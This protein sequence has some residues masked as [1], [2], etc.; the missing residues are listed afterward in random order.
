MKDNKQKRKE[1]TYT[2]DIQNLIIA[3]KVDIKKDR[4]AKIICSDLNFLGRTIKYLF[5]E[6]E[7]LSDEQAGN[8]ICNVIVEDSNQT[9]T[10]KDL[11]IA[12]KYIDVSFSIK[13]R[14]VKIKLFIEPN[15]YK[16]NIDE[17]V[18]RSLEY[19]AGYYLKEREEYKSD[20]T[21]GVDVYGIWIL[22]S[23]NRAGTSLIWEGDIK[24]R[25]GKIK[26]DIKLS[27]HLCFHFCYISNEYDKVDKFKE[28]LV[29]F[30]STV[31]SKIK[32]K[33][34]KIKLLEERQ[35]FKFRERAQ[36]EIK[37]NGLREFYA[38]ADAKKIRA[39]EAE[40]QSKDEVIRAKDEV[41]R[42]IGEKVKTDNIATLKG[43]MLDL[44]LDFD[45]AFSISRLDPS[46]K[47]EYRKLIEE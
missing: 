31:F 3:D 12:K 11:N 42:A 1:E 33:D 37:M 34:D 5:K 16:L 2:S 15:F 46:L 10:L 40:I 18:T 23:E 26:Q 17:L 6:Y 39:L 21:K 14:P 28:P 47:E 7:N 8:L 27:S 24:D 19:G 30:Y 36:E 13:N 25:D 29:C 45:K 38:D 41:I 32:D 22:N 35:S 20:Y 9:G 44:N 4:T 43:V